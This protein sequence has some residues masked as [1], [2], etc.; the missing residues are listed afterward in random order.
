M[1]AMG[2]RAGQGLANAKHQTPTIVLSTSDP[3]ASGIITS[4]EDSGFD[5]VH[6]RVDPFRY[7]RQVQI[8]YDIIGFQKL[9]VAYENTNAGRS[10]A[11]IDKVEKVAKEK[12]FDIISCYTESDV[13][14]KKIAEESVI[15]SFHELGKKVDAIYVTLQ[16]GVNSRSIPELVK[17]ANS[18][19]LPTFSQSGSDEV[20]YGFLMSISKANFK[21]VGL[22]YAETI[23]KIFNGAKPRQLDQIFE[24]PTSISINL[25]TAEIIGYDPPLDVMAIAD[26]I[27]Y[28]IEKPEE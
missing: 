21:Y 28:E 22:F 19:H 3:I 27:Y 4:V 6:A 2:T 7:E 26:E 9:G 8:F 11:A 1:I 18:Y 15:K 13:A 20:K 10:Y 12:G 25:K 14:D 16:R 24:A 17:I 5:H 23:A